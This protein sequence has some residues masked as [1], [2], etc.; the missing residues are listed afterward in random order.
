[1][2]TTLPSAAIIGAGSSGIAAAKALHERGVP[3]TCFEAS[4]RVGGNWVFGNR[5]GMSA[6]YRQLHINTSRDRM[7]YSDYP[8][9]KSYPDYPHHTHIAAYFD[10]YVD[11]FGFRE[12]IRFDTRVQRARRGA[13]GVWEL[14]L[15]DGS[16]AR[17]DALLVAN[18]HHWD[19]RWPE[20]MLPGHDSF[21]GEQLHAH[22]YVDND[23]FAGRDVVILGMGNSAMDIAVESSYV[24]RRTY[25][26]ARR[27]AWVI[28]KYMFGRPVD[29]LPQDP[30]VPFKVRQRVIQTLIRLHVGDPT[31]YGLPRP[32]HKFGEAHPTVSGRI[33]DRIQHGTI[34]P[35]P[36]I[37]R[38]DGDHVEFEDGTR[39]HVDVV[40]YCTG[41][42]I[43]FP[44]FDDAFVSA[45]DNHIELFRRVFHPDHDDLFFVALLQPLGATMPLAEAQGQ[46]IADYLRGEYALP[47]R[48]ALVK[49]IEDDMA[50]MR[51]RYVASK[52]H[53]IQVDFDDYLRAL[54]KER[55][56]GAQRARERGFRLPVAPRAGDRVAA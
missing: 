53:T 52:R 31:R 27:G 38:L 2:Q 17:F 46:W 34:A 3:F 30:R 24:A 14:T 23:L 22:A 1:M 37:R 5:N 18:G 8:M 50:A 39:E 11:H 4:D 26:S 19:P 15:D 51:K 25:L 56:A 48:A 42:K 45:P 47:A 28:P 13:D 43:S 33:L 7:E 55:R 41:Y 20:P 29:Q 9:P 21:A 10:A 40:V 16:V 12:R 36:N 35:K 6:A 54:E 32:D 44:F 49:D